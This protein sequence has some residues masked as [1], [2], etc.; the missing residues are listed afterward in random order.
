MNV[1]FG[2][3]AGLRVNGNAVWHED[4]GRDR[5][6]MPHQAQPGA[7]FGWAVAAGDYNRDGLADLAVGVPFTDQ[8]GQD[9]A[10]LVHVLQGSAD[11]GLVVWPPG[12][13]L[14]THLHVGDPIRHQDWLGYALGAGD[15]NGDRKVDLAI[16]APVFALRDAS[17]VHVL[18][19]AVHLYGPGWNKYQSWYESAQKLEEGP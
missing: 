18:W 13:R 15:V 11:A 5:A 1:I 3:S 16:A 4:N 17:V 8:N 19:G 2:S 14:W 9:R 7:Q 10:G 6:E 12:D